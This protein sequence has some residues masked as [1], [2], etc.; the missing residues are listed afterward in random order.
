M[1]FSIYSFPRVFNEIICDPNHSQCF[2]GEGACRQDKLSLTILYDLDNVGRNALGKWK[3]F[4]RTFRISCSCGIL[5]KSL[6]RHLL[7]T[8][9][10]SYLQFFFCLKNIGSIIFINPRRPC[11]ENITYF[12]EYCSK[13]L[14][15]FKVCMTFLWTLGV[16]RLK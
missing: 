11:I 4:Q 3:E 15:I 10:S 9:I 8:F 6:F 12:L 14:N 1:I 2:Y 7:W 13:C 16:T 5:E